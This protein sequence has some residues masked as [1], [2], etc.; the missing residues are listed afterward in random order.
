MAR[1]TIKGVNGTGTNLKSTTKNNESPMNHKKTL[2]RKL[3]TLLI[4]EVGSFFTG[5]FDFF[6]VIF[7]AIIYSK[8]ANSVPIKLP[9][10]TPI[11]PKRTPQ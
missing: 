4:K 2:N 6:G 9:I 11:P 8:S 3:F 7:V 10:A 5:C 1:M